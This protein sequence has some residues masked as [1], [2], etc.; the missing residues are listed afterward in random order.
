MR[1]APEAAAA[2]CVSGPDSSANLEKKRKRISTENIKLILQCVMVV[3][4]VLSFE[5]KI[6]Y[7]RVSKIFSTTF[8]LF[9]SMSEEMYL[10]HKTIGTRDCH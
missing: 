4:K 6:Y 10:Y 7:K 2:L 1:P 8:C 9:I 3:K 5:Q